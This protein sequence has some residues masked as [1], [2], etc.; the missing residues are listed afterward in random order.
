MVVFDDDIEIC[1]TTQLQNLEEKTN[2]EVELEIRIK[3]T[4][5]GENISFALPQ[6]TNWR[7]QMEETEKI[8]K[9][10]HFFPCQLFAEELRAN[11][12]T[13]IRN[14]VILRQQ[15]LKE[16]D[17]VWEEQAKFYS[18]LNDCPKDILY[19][20][21]NYIFPGQS[22]SQKRLREEGLQRGLKYIIMS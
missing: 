19:E 5:N 3:R 20:I 18:C 17:A 2:T 14:R 7:K 6:K 12:W 16:F 1:G 22:D 9:E 4:K 21:V 10:K 8:L 13:K 15:Y 11:K